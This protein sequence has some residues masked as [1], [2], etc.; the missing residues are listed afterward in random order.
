MFFND[1][2]KEISALIKSYNQEIIKE[3]VNIHEYAVSSTRTE[4][5]YFR[6]FFPALETYLNSLRIPGTYFNCRTREIHGT[7]MVTF[8]PRQ[9][10]E[11]GDYFIVVKYLKNNILIGQKT[12]VYQLKRSHTN[13]WNI[14]QRQLH[15]LKNWPSFNFGRTY[16]GIN[17][18]R[19]RPTRPEY[20]SYVLI[21]S[22]YK[23][24]FESNIYGT[25]YDIY[26]NQNGTRVQ[27]RDKQKFYYCSLF[28]YFNLLTWENGEPI[29]P[30]TD[31]EDFNSALYR[32][33][34]WEQNEEDEFKNFNK[35]TSKNS[36]W[37]VEITIGIEEKR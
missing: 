33:M 24:F 34:N 26:N 18:F 29:T 16:H 27:L 1:E 2:A 4:L 23:G 32:Y 35:N 6:A 12:I 9:T 21:N 7:P 31:I 13:S 37:G 3:F 36:F 5:Q 25:A 19:L 28:S 30:N 20:G 15:F 10:C 8:G 22:L 17:S 11:L 14:N